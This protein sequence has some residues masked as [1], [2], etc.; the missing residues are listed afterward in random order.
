MAFDK[1]VR[2]IRAGRTLARPSL[3]LQQNRC[4]ST[5]R[6]FRQQRRFEAYKYYYSEFLKLIDLLMMDL[7]SAYLLF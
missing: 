5:F 2:G 6:T 1:G 3:V 4:F 7:K